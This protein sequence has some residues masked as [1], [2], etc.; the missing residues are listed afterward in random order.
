MAAKNLTK[1]MEAFLNGCAIKDFAEKLCNR[2][3]E[4]GFIVY[5][6]DASSTNSVYLK[7]DYGVCNSIRISDHVGKGYLKY[8]YNIGSHIK[9]MNVT[10][11]TY[12]RYFYPYADYEAMIKQ[13]MADRDTKVK[14]Y[15]RANYERFMRENKQD[16]QKD[17]GFWTQA[18]R[19]M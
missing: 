4:A 19:V 10:T 16:H 9:D 13:I 1:Q 12:P 17:K 5:R 15:G 14:K 18:H 3:I 7:L 2:L 8:R 6:Y 11:D